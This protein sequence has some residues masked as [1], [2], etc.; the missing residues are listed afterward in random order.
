MRFRLCNGRVKW[1]GGNT[2]IEATAYDAEWICIQGENRI[3]RILPCKPTNGDWETI[4]MWMEEVFGY[5]KKGIKVGRVRFYQIFSSSS[6]ESK[7]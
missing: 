4:P 1:E 6:Y 5:Y 3:W 7:A 2:R